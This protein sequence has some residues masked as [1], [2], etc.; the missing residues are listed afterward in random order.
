MIQRLFYSCLCIVHDCPILGK[1]DESVMV[2]LLKDPSTGIR[3][4]MSERGYAWARGIPGPDGSESEWHLRLRGKA[5]KT[6]S[7]G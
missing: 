2:G 6:L 3:V 5:W 4:I 7:S 1:Q